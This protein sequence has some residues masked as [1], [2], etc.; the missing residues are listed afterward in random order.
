MPIPSDSRWTLL[1][2]PGVKSATRGYTLHT[3]QCV[4]GTIRT[5]RKQTVDEGSSRSC[6]CLRRELIEQR[7]QRTRA[8]YEGKTVGEL[9]IKKLSIP[10]KGGGRE[11][12]C[13]CS[14]GKEVVISEV[15]NIERGRTRSC[16]HL[17]DD[18]RTSGGSAITHGMSNTRHF[19]TF[20]QLKLRYGREGAAL[21]WKDYYDFSA[22]TFEAYEVLNDKD[23]AA[24]ALKDASKPLDKANWKWI[25]RMGSPLHL[26]RKRH[27][28][29]RPFTCL[30][31]TLSQADWARKMGLT[32]ERIRQLMNN[33]QLEQRILKKLSP[34]MLGGTD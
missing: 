25:T 14:C 13:V 12:L 22:D 5:L 23:A 31:L 19:R 18:W 15:N 9:T 7:D 30:G 2:V 34:T 24:F 32:R 10:K 3:Y 17:L 8:K 4:C 6:G 26:P 33:G 21:P 20:T 16:G 29:R 28:I 11:A 27:P 1:P